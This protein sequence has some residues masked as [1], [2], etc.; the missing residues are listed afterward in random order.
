MPF[1]LRDFALEG[2]QAKGELVQK[3]CQTVAAGEPRAR[4][5]CAITPQYRNMFYWLADDMRPVELARAACRQIGWSPS[6]SR[7]AAAPMA[8][9]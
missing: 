1:I 8:P 4:I 3:A 5:A 7:S 9:A 2:L 6:T